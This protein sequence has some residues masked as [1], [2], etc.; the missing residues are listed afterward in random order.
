MSSTRTTSARRSVPARPLYAKLRPGP[1]RDHDAVASN[2]R[3]R[4]I[5]AMIE[6]VAERG[7]A[8]ATVARLVA[9]AGVSKRTFYEL[10]GTKEAYFLATYDAIVGNAI[11]RIGVAYRSEGDWLARLRAGFAAY[12]AEV[13]HEPKAAR[14]VLV[15]VLGAGPAALARM[16]HTR[17]IFEEMVRVSLAEAPDSVTVP[18]LIA[19][20]IACGV[21]RV[22]RQWLLADA[23]DELPARMDELLGWTLSYRAPA[24]AA[25][26]ASS[27]Y[28]GGAV[29]RE[30]PARGEG[31]WARILR[32]AAQ[33]AAANG[34]AQLTSARIAR[35]AG[36]SQTRFD[37]LFESTEQCFL[38]AVD[39]LGLETLVCAARAFQDLS[40]QA[41]GG[42][43]GACHAMHRAI[44]ALMRHLAADPV[45][46][47]VAFV[48]MFA[49]GPAGI[50]ER[51]HV[52]SQFTDELMR[53]LPRSR[54]PSRVV[55]DAC[56]GAIWGIVHDH[57]TR[58][59]THLLP[60]LVDQVTYIVL[61]PVIGGD[62]AIR[63][64]VDSSETPAVRRR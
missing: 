10:F 63:T 35:T 27:P 1:T 60:A 2:Q 24:A 11:R 21:E 39:R 30:R 31:D 38:Q 44:A 4:L 50:G 54:A 40:G 37:E 17:L 28:G 7:Y 9:L 3:S 47:R 59:A 26:A 56:V 19:K 61:A 33:I 57:V 14:L 22:T 16:R 41:P 18:P 32:C 5:G 36:V 48:E 29:P 45:V 51:E 64:I 53:A 6:E 62:A 25:L 52:L 49:L 15:E 34:Y 8:D 13:A 23:L 43:Q 55:L 42:R 46:L 58:G 12:A 20:G